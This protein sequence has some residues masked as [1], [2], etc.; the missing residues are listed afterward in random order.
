MEEGVI[1]E[2]EVKGKKKIGKNH[3]K[4]KEKQRHA[5]TCRDI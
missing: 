4:Q 3:N 2:N 5:E 1:K